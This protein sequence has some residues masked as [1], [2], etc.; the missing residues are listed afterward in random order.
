MFI[1]SN[2]RFLSNGSEF[3][4]CFFWSSLND[5]S[6]VEHFIDSLQTVS[7]QQMCHGQSNLVDNT[8]RKVWFLIVD[9]C[10][11]LKTAK[12]NWKFSHFLFQAIDMSLEIQVP[13]F[14]RV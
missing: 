11:S 5:N 7:G 4:E 14:L 13:V 3:Y 1:P 8:S 10:K 12:L 6:H 2:I 9:W